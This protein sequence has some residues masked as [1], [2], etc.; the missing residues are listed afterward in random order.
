[1]PLNA[2]VLMRRTEPSLQVLGAGVCEARSAAE[3][4]F[5][6]AGS[7]MLPIPLQEVDSG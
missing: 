7:P 1:M 5:G 4:H 3:A 2:R 6:Q